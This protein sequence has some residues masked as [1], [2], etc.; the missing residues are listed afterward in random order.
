L[1]PCGPAV[2]GPDEAA[3]PAGYRWLVSTMIARALALE[4]PCCTSG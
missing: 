4:L 2:A 3:C 1:S